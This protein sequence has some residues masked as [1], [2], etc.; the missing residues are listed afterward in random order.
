MAN[1]FV[2]EWT[3]SRD[4]KPQAVRQKVEFGNFDG[5]VEGAQRE[6]DKLWPFTSPH[7][8]NPKVVSIVGAGEVTKVLI[9]RDAPSNAAE[10]RGP[11]VNVAPEPKK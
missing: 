8:R 10:G 2:V 4:G 5:N 3:E 7:R 9:P 1:V 6:I 11:T